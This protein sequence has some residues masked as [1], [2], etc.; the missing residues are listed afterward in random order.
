[1][2]F[3]NLNLGDIFRDSDG[4]VCIKL[5]PHEDRNAA[6]MNGAMLWF[7]G[8]E[9]VTPVRLVLE[10]TCDPG[11]LTDARIREIKHGDDAT[12]KEVLSLAGE[13]RERRR[14]CTT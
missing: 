7:D 2:R 3:V 6:T 13:V 12:R 8:G 4:D 1:M 5:H 14:E 9:Q 11:W 10:P